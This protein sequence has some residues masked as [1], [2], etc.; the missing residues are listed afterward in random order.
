M[1]FLG[2]SSKSRQGE[3]SLLCL[4]LPGLINSTRWKIWLT[5][6]MS[7]AMNSLSRARRSP[8]YKAEGCVGCFRVL[9]LLPPLLL[10][11]GTRQRRIEALRERHASLRRF[12]YLLQKPHEVYRCQRNWGRRRWIDKHEAH[13]TMWCP[14]GTYLEGLDVKTFLP[15]KVSDCFLAKCTLLQR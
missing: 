5:A 4:L 9:F 1:G 11:V 3:I 15:S 14:P 8:N 6:G 7:N 10:V 2:H 12:L 13:G